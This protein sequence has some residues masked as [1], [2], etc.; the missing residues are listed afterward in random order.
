[1]ACGAFEGLWERLRSSETS[2]ALF[3]ESSFILNGKIDSGRSER[4]FWVDAIRFWKLLGVCVFFGQIKKFGKISD[5]MKN[6]FQ[7][8]KN[9]Q[10]KLVEIR[11]KPGIL[12]GQS[13]VSK[14]GQNEGK[15]RPIW[16]SYAGF[17]P[18]HLVEPLI[19]RDFKFTPSFN[20]MWLT[21]AV[22]LGAKFNG[23]A[24][25]LRVLRVSVRKNLVLGFPW[26]GCLILLQ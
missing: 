24:W 15:N 7:C 12:R 26:K 16:R 13:G 21:N 1:M 8:L 18:M 9:G 11:S 17:G 4:E 25:Y 19:T 23:I 20:T 6:V 10:N 3:S 2:S 5:G 14:M 22:K